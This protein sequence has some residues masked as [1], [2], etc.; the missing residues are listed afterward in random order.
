METQRPA[1]TALQKIVQPP[2]AAAAKPAKAVKICGRDGCILGEKHPGLCVIPMEE[3][4]RIG[5]QP[6]HAEPKLRSRRRSILVPAA[7]GGAE[8]AAK[9]K[10]AAEKALGRE[11]LDNCAPEGCA[12]LFGMDA[13]TGYKGD[14]VYEVEELVDRRI[15]WRRKEYKVRWN[16]LAA[17][18]VGYMGAG[19]EY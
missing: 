8:A 7:A 4:K 19:E 14:D 6:S 5:R 10:P 16:W 1:S 11:E 2:P 18:R 13:S 3:E 17:R 12:V 9:A 15:R